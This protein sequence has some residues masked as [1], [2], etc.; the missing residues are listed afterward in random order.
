MM[1]MF[2]K[3]LLGCIVF[4]IMMNFADA[5]TDT[6]AM[7]FTLQQCLDLALKNNATVQHSEITSE[8]QRANLQQ[9]RGNMLPTLNGSIDHGV[10]QGRSIDPFTNTYANQN[11]SFANYGLNSS[12]TL[13]NA[14]AI[15]NS[16][17][18]NR[19]AFDAT[20]MEIQQNKDAIAL[21]VIL[22]YLQVLTN[23][24]LA[25]ASAEQRDVSGKQV[26]RLTIL[27]SAGSIAPSDLYDLKGQYAQN[28]LNVVNAEN[29]LESAKVLLSQLLNV[30]Y[31]KNMV[32]ERIGLTDVEGNNSNTDSIYQAALQNLALVKASELRKQSAR[33]GVKTYRSLRFPSLY[34][35]GSLGTNYS[36]NATTQQYI[37]STDVTT[38]NY[39][40]VNGDKIPLIEKQDNFT[41]NKINYGDQFKNN[42]NTTFSIGIRI[43]LLNNLQNKT[44]IKTAELLEKDAEITLNA[45]K[46]QLQQNIEQAYVNLNSAQKRYDVLSDQVNAFKESFREAE[47]KFNA[48]VITSDVYLIA[49]NNYDNANINL[50]IARYDYVFRSMILDYYSGK[51]TF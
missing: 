50:I 1:M 48:G 35:S 12:L 39:V 11:I 9:A 17:K 49:K 44:Q 18:Q 4:L 30:P 51:L 26:E 31:N 47:V 43:P 38:D 8:T 7:R 10:S 46:T 6:S 23:V 20:K 19:L 22:Q 40:V 36:S 15:Q 32:V 14:F 25:Q 13:F 5:Q 33:F 42:Y 45:T 37:N 34:L 21:Q 2:R 24:D 29:N 16:I 28:E 41:S 3:F 27:D